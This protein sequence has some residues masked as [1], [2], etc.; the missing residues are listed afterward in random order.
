MTTRGKKNPNTKGKIKTIR[1][2]ISFGFVYF[3]KTRNR[4]N[5]AKSNT[6]TILKRKANPRSNP[7]KSKIPP[8]FKGWI[9]V[10]DFIVEKIRREDKIIG[11]SIKFSAFAILPSI[12]GNPKS[13]AYIAV[14]I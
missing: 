1:D 12:I 8:C 6:A 10:K 14:E 11:K 5:A 4:K 7:L 2:P 9:N 3:A 13:K